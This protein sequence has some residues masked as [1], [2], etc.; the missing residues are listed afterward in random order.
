MIAMTGW[1][2]KDYSAAYSFGAKLLLLGGTLGFLSLAGLLQN[3]SGSARSE[4]LPVRQA[5]NEASLERLSEESP[6]T[7][8]TVSRVDINRS[9][10]EDLQ[11]LP[12][13]GP[14]LAERIFLYRNNNQNFMSIQ[15]IQNVKGIGAKRFARLRPYI[16]VDQKKI[17]PNESF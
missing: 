11:R 8:A 14:V 1:S 3:P 6:V 16:R 5:G 9:S 17:A 7:V 12:G 13:I 2:V 4:A 10:V 15:D